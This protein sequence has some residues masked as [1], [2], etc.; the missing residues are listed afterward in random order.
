MGE[1]SNKNERRGN[2]L[3]KNH[4]SDQNQIYTEMKHRT[5]TYRLLNT[6][7]SENITF[8]DTTGRLFG[9]I[10]ICAVFTKV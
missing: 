5:K 6:E 2:Y 3:N 1:D 8:L 7:M 10:L 4:K 9:F